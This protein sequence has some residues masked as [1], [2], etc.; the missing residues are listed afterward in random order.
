MNKIAF[1][2][3]SKKERLTMK[4]EILAVA[5]LGIFN[6]AEEHSVEMN[7]QIQSGLFGRTYTVSRDD[8]EKELFKKDKAKIDLMF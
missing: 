6:K 4:E 1:N 8:Y 2:R 7:L 3:N 5:R